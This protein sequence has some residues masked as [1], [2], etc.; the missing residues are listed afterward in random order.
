[1]DLDHP[2]ALRENGPKTWAPFVGPEAELLQLS[3]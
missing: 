2:Q 3:G 1:M